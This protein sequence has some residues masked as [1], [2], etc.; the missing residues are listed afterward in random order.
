LGLVVVVPVVGYVGVAAMKGRDGVWPTL[1]GPPER[2]AVVFEAWDRAPKANEYILC[3]A[4]YCPGPTDGVAPEFSVPV[5]ELQAAW[6]RMVARQPLTTRLSWNVA[7]LQGDWEVRTPLLRFPDTVTVRFLPLG[8][9]RSTLAVYS[10]SHYG[11]SD[12]GTNAKRVTR[13]L[14]ALDEEL[15]A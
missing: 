2:G 8:E 9:D 3:P 10:R 11:K 7:Q 15:A 1:F 14:N 5:A 12:L 6:D 13:W 4:G